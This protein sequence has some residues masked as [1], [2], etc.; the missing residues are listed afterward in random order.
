MK[1]RGVEQ[2]TISVQIGN[3]VPKRRVRPVGSYQ[4]RHAQPAMSMTP[5]ACD[6]NE[7]RMRVKLGQRHRS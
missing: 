5:C 4:L 6:V 2:R 3:G 1:H 7:G